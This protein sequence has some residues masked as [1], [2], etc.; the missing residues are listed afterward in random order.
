M[1]L[2]VL[3]VQAQIE[4]VLP[5]RGASSLEGTSFVIGFMQNEVLEVGIDPRLQIFISSQYDA[6]VK[7]DLPLWG[8]QTRY[9]RANTV[10]VEDVS[11]YHVM[12]ASEIPQKK[13]VFITSD[14]PIVVYVL[15]TLAAS[16]DTYT[17]IP[18]K[19]LGTQYLTVN[20]P[21]DHYPFNPQ[22]QFPDLDTIKRSSEF[23][24]IAQKDFTVVS[25]TPTFRT[26]QGQRAG[27]PFWVT[28][29]KGECYLVQAGWSPL[30][31]GD[32]S[33]S[34]IESSEQVAVLSG[35]V[36]SSIPTTASYSKDHLVEMLPPLSTWGKE[37]ITTPFAIVQ[38]GDVVRV[39]AA[40]VD[41]RVD[42]TSDAGTVTQ[43][44]SRPGEWRDFVITR[45]AHYKSDKAFFVMQF[46]PSR[47][48][49]EGTSSN[50]DPA[51]VVVPPLEQYVMG[52]LLQTPQ[53]E[54]QNNLGGTQRFFHFV[55]VVADQSALATLRI[56]KTLV[57]TAAPEIANQRVVGTNKHW[58]VLQ[59]SPGVHTITADTGLFSGVM[60]GTTNADSYAN[61]FG[62]TYEPIDME[63]RTPPKYLLTV[64]CGKIRGAVRDSFLPAK[65]GRLTELNVIQSRTYNYRWAISNP[66]DSYGTL[67]FSANVINLWK[68]AEIVV[69]AYDNQGWGTEWSYFYDAPNIKV[70]DEIII[71][72]P[73]RQAVCDSLPI[74]NLDSTPVHIKGI[75]FVGDPRL[76]LGGSGF[77]DTRI[78]SLGTLWVPLCFT[79]DASNTTA[80]GTIIVD[81]GCGLEVSIKVR[82]I[83]TASLVVHDLDFGDVLIGDTVCKPFPIIN[84][85]STI[86][87][88]DAVKLA[89]IIEFIVDTAA[90]LLPRDL[91]P[92]DTMWVDVCFSPGMER[93]YGRT[94]SILSTPV[95]QGRSTYT[96]R[97]VRPRIHDIVVDWG[98]RRLGTRSD[99][100]MQLKND[101][102]APCI[103]GSDAPY[104][105]D[106]A[107]DLTKL[108]L[109][110]SITQGSAHPV[111]LSYSPLQR[112]MHA[113]TVPLRVDWTLHEPVRLVVRGQGTMPEMVV[114]TID[115]GDVVVGNVRDSVLVVYYANV[116][117]EQLTIDRISVV[118][119]DDGSF[120]VPTNVTTVSVVAESATVADR[121][122]FA[123][124]RIG[125]H[126]MYLEIVH[127]G[128]PNYERRT[129]MVVIM[130]NGI[131]ELTTVV[132]V[133]LSTSSTT[134][135]CLEHDATLTM[136]NTGTSAIMVDSCTARFGA[137]DLTVEADL[138]RLL[139]PGARLEFSTWHIPE[140]GGSG[141]LEMTVHYNDTVSITRSSW[142]DVEVEPLTVTIPTQIVA[143]PGTPVDV[144]V[145]ISTSRTRDVK[146]RI[147]F[148]VMVDAE[149][150]IPRAGVYACTITDALGNRP[151]NATVTLSANGAFVEVD[152]QVQ[153]PFT[154][155]V[156][157]PG[158]SLW[159]DTAQAVFNVVVRS[160]VCSD[161]GRA[162]MVVHGTLCAGTLRSVSLN[163]L[164]TVSIRVL[165]VPA[166]DEVHVIADATHRT[167]VDIDLMSL[168]GQ[169]ESLAQQYTLEKGSS[170]CIFKLC[171]QSA[172]MYGLIVRTVSG[173]ITIPLLVVK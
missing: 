173:D 18:I 46:M 140:R 104:T 119:P 141:L 51:M 71:D 55:N 100:T 132:D 39:M 25:I 127:D 118:G 111:A 144:P 134:P 161:E 131:A 85:G 52:A 81:L 89:S 17:A 31:G 97:G 34:R 82:T 99:T 126:I 23:M 167:H 159:K 10:H 24:V 103:V 153:A 28:L 108:G 123:P 9:V 1:T 170:H 172:G 62:V 154:I 145:T 50:Y 120:T 63:H 151:G 27:T 146:E 163:A 53:L 152:Q 83:A 70:Q 105:N 130:G 165:E 65:A 92:G 57:T 93:S 45:A 32:L 166:R 162:A 54:T 5:R 80:T 122:A 84:N 96:G 102:S 148:D 19:H 116:G 4:R 7:I 40:D 60:Y 22:L 58:A 90:L 30:G 3:D 15:N 136:S 138:P 139:L 171:V 75:R 29:N 37:Y 88:I 48:P 59:I 115:M 133:D 49:R 87:T 69:Q 33:G 101:G 43:W 79:P 72:S 12:N 143:D 41:T 77:V 107:F 73:S 68:D 114:D 66:T 129:D 86:V 76:S 156:T 155:D 91:A 168:T 6:V 109:P 56:N 44:F 42:I 112:G 16:S 157:V 135:S 14:V 36:R 13:G 26:K 2:A 61:L 95:M 64:D 158:L 169:I 164:P 121:L 11:P 149:R 38:G 20:Q 147:Q 47:R 124:L 67:D 8:E 35:H 98:R 113:D 106:A 94:D 74:L 137:Q 117:N 21:A 128:A 150:W 110:T 160:T 125:P 78:D 142:V